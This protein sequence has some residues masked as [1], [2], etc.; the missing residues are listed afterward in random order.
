MYPCAGTLFIQG[1]EL[2]SNNNK[3]NWEI[4][5]PEQD[6][7]EHKLFLCQASLT[8][9]AK[10]GERNIIRVTWTDDN[11]ETFSYVIASLR[12]GQNESVSLNLGLTSSA[13]LS[14]VSGS[15]PVH[16]VGS[17]LIGVYDFD[18]GSELESEDEEESMVNGNSCQQNIEMD[19]ENILQLN[20]FGINK[21]K[22]ADEESDG[23]DE[24]DEEDDID[25][26][27]SSED[28]SVDE[29]QSVE[30]VEEEKPAI[31]KQKKSSL[32]KKGVLKA[33]SVQKEQVVKK[34]TFSDDKNKKQ[35]IVQKAKNIQE[36]K[37]QL[38]KI[39]NLPKTLE[40][41]SNF[42]KSNLKIQDSKLIND[43][44]LWASKNKK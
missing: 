32:Q 23:S 43:A 8:E 35:T 39:H 30:E 13:T 15:G 7:F 1:C 37:K 14:L 21:K 9:N 11:E 36:V 10:E 17:H 3:Y 25:Q 20:K 5:D 42:M 41:F 6:D 22:E 28:E 2:N 38:E 24:D 4:P 40:K 19:K 16:L 33:K 31:S 27:E 12:I 26:E 34:V 18:E 29:S 44:W